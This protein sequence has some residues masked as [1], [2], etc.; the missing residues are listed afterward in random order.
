MVTF[1][2]TQDVKTQYPGLHFETIQLHLQGEV[3]KIT[4]GARL[5]VEGYDPLIVQAAPVMRQPIAREKTRQV[6]IID[7]RYMTR[8]PNAFFPPSLLKK[9]SKLDLIE[10][11]FYPES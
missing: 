6:A 8:D 10:P 4:P 7:V 11:Y 1:T 5:R 2:L 9:R 3:S